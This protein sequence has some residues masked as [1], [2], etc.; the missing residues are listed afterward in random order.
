MDVLDRYR[1]FVRIAESGGFSRAARALGLPRATASAAIQ[2]LEAE[3]GT[4]LFHRTTRDVSL[5]A[6]GAQLL[7]RVRPLLAQADG[8]EQLFQARR[9]QVSGRLNVDV[10]SRMARRLVAPAL[11]GLLHR[12]PRL[13]LALG[14]SDRPADVVREGLDCVVRVGEVRAPGLVRRSLGTLALVNCASA[15][16]VREFGEPRDPSELGHAHAMI[17]YAPSA[18][19]R[20][21]P[22]EW[23]DATGTHALTPACRVIVDSAESYIACC[24]AGLGLVQ[25]PRYDVQHL[26]ASGELV[27]VLPRHPPGGM[28]VSVLYP[29]RR[30]RS[31]RLVAFMTWFE[32]LLRP[33]LAP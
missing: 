17:G 13:Q 11:P 5:T 20:A 14:C 6:D 25:V 33:H 30:Q 28:E 23:E 22:W 3:L 7:E 31:A 29:H 19:A 9:R 16:Y 12:H 2:R 24:R 21:A 10:P 32:G 1:L 15:G 8:V 26:L 18:T 27:A 4:R